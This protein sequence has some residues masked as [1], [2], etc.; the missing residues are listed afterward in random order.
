ME[1]EF[2]KLVSDIMG[3]IDM[4]R[5]EATGF[6]TVYCPIC[7]KMERKTG[8]FKFE[9]DAIVYNCFRGSCDA[10]TVYRMGEPISRKFKALMNELGVTIPMPLRV[11]R[12]SIQKTMERELSKELYEPNT[13]RDVEIPEHWIPL[14][15]ADGFFA[16]K[17]RT[18][19][20]ERACDYT[21]TWLISRGLY[22]NYIAIVLRYYDKVI[23]VQIV[24]GNNDGAKYILETENEG[25][26]YLPEHTPTS[27]QI[28]VEGVLDAKCFPN[29]CATLRSKLNPKQAYHI[30][31][32]EWWFLPDKSSN[33]FLEQMK[34]YEGS[35]IIIPEWDYHDLN[36][37]VCNL[38]VMEVAKIIKESV[39][40]N[41][42]EAVIKYKL[43]ANKGD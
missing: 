25:C 37:A 15:E 3:S 32:G 28:I 1:K 9:M 43:W 33:N 20:D 7:K 2:Q 29:T 16:D 21:D 5:A 14:A 4:G 12:S 11:V 19:L 35:K 17:W 23:G 34:Q 13:F 27:P 42:R 40:D 8:G 26:L 38:G 31:N 36:E 24:T 39:V 18:H 10:S 30:R 22:K 41:Y 6:H